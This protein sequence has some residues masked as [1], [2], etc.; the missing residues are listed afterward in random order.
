[1][2][3]TEPQPLTDLIDRLD[4]KTPIG[5]AMRTAEWE[6]VPQG[7]RDG[8]FFS[9]GVTHTQFLAAQQKA[10]TDIIARAKETN[11]AGESMWKMDRGQFVKQLR[12]MGEALGV[13]H[14]TG[15]EGGIKERDITD[16]LSIARLQL[17]VNTQLELAY[18]YGQYVTAMDEDVL[19]EWPAWELVRI[20][21]RKAPRDWFQRWSEAGGTLH[22]GRMIALKTDPIWAK[23]SRFG[24]PHPPFDFNSGMGVEEVDRDT[25]ESLGLMSMSM[26]EALQDFATLKFQTA[27]QL[28]AGRG[29]FNLAPESQQPGL[30]AFQEGLEASVKDVPPG[31][32][33][34]LKGIFKSKIN[35]DGDTVQ[36]AQDAPENDDL[37]KV[38]D[39]KPEPQKQ[40]EKIPS[41]KRSTF[42]QPEMFNPIEGREVH[43]EKKVKARIE[44]ASLMQGG[45][46]LGA[47]NELA[48]A[49]AKGRK[50]ITKFERDTLGK[51][52]ERARA[53][54]PTGEVLRDQ[55]IGSERMVSLADDALPGA[56]M[57]HLHPRD[58]PQSIED[59]HLLLKFGMQEVRAVTTQGVYSIR[60]GAAGS[61]PRVAAQAV[62]TFNSFVSQAQAVISRQAAAEGWNADQAERAIHHAVLVLM[63]DRGFIHYSLT[64]WEA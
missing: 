63:H 14:P 54:D 59:L 29:K 57:S 19:Q 5:S 24:N 6:R 32:R 16:P 28:K 42:K 4:A 15:R 10:V 47:S 36:W 35:I 21:P 46:T 11:A 8:A 61:G 3:F 48:E 9:A 34:K 39:A 49:T 60:P 33:Q 58:M 41:K 53:Y 17:V 38:K 23:L 43:V 7:L 18:G 25:A 56:V 40:P 2:V 52:L 50:A 62:L 22:D 55:K 45:F 26:N 44:Q 13:Q 12:Q 20:T 31:M 37:V 30:K 27:A 64:P 1:M 51:R